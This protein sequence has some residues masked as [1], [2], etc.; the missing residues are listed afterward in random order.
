MVRIITAAALILVASSAFAAAP[1]GSQYS[2]HHDPLLGYSASDPTVVTTAGAYVGRD[3][4][5]SI[6][7]ELRRFP[8]PYVSGGF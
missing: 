6:R 8:G 7:A 1:H 2:A 5:P 3:P 4:D